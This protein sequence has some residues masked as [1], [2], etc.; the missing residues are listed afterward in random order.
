MY[1]VFCF[2]CCRRLVAVGGWLRVVGCSLL[3]I[4]VVCCLLFVI[5]GLVVLRCALLVA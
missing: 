5:C 2:V 3:E 1:V 4:V